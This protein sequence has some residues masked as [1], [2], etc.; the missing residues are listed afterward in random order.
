MSTSAI[1]TVLDA[2]VDGLRARPG[3]NGVNIFS[4]Y[5]SLEESGL[6]SI[7][8]GDAT[9]TEEE[10]AMGGA[11]L[12]TWDVECVLFGQ[13]KSWEGDTETTIR[14]ARDRGLE[15]FAEV[16]SYV[17]QTY[18]SGAYPYVAMA[19]GKLESGYGPETRAARLTFTL[20]VLAFKNP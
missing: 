2:L 9:L 17:N 18:L 1:G 7:E 8:L 13:A 10:L 5:V 11:R 12:E 16:E 19:A 15:L 14:A 4:A 20:R 3:L 6:E